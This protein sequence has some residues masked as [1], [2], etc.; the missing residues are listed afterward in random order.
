MRPALPLPSSLLAICSKEGRPFHGVAAL[1]C[2]MKM[3]DCYMFISAPAAQYS[4]LVSVY[5][6]L[7]GISI[8][9]CGQLGRGGQGQDP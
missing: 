9:E 7:C 6:F 2:G 5:Y 1:A 8:P 3:T 4:Y